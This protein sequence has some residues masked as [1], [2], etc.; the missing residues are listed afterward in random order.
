MKF[1]KN[2]NP[3]SKT[4]VDWIKVTHQCRTL[5][6]AGTEIITVMVLYKVLTLLANPTIYI[7]WPHTAKPMKAMV[8]IENCRERRPDSL[9][10]RYIGSKEFIKPK[11]GMMMIYT[12]GCP[13]NQNRC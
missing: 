8:Y 5:V 6:E 10:L 2:K 7:W 12:S 3:T 11:Q 1:S 9:F 13:K 4:S